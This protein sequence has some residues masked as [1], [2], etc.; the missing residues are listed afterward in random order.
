MPPY[1]WATGTT[2]RQF[3]MRREIPSWKNSTLKSYLNILLICML[4]MVPEW[5]LQRRVTLMFQKTFLHWFE[6]LPVETLLFRCQ[7]CG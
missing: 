3:A 7:T 1:L 2:S 6:K 4:P 5:S